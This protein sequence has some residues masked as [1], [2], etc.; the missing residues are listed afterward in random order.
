MTGSFTVHERVPSKKNSYEVHCD[1]RFWRALVRSG[2]TK[3]FVRRWWIAP[4]QEVKDFES[5]VAW[6]AKAKLPDFGSGPV[7]VTVKLHG[8][9]DRD[10]ALGAI[11]DG[12]QLSGRIAN[13]RQVRRIVVES[14]EGGV[15]ADITVEALCQEATR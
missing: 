9:V 5:L 11:L 2:L 1:P 7:S 3:L 13:D 12:L 15:G 14:V 10:N 6:S 4:S 8:S